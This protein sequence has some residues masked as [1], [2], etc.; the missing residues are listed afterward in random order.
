MPFM[1]NRP[2]NQKMNP[3][4]GHRRHIQLGLK[5]HHHQ[6]LNRQLNVFHFMIPWKLLR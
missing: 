4:L 3:Q 2:K 1:R 5:Y 6:Y